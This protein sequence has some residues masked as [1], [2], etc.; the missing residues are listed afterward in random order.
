MEQES[1]M[2][3]INC[4]YNCKHGEQ[5]WVIEKGCSRQTM[6]CVVKKEL[7]KPNNKCEKWEQK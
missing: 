7:V 6:M 4:C 3:E 5:G 2:T 1:R